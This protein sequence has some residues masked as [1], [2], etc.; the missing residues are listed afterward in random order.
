M[1]SYTVR[2]TWVNMNFIKTVDDKEKPR[3]QASEVANE[4]LRA[5]VKAG[6]SRYTPQCHPA[7]VQAP[8]RPLLWA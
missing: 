4:S 6:V 8:A 7:R 2:V 5:S 3:F 1:I